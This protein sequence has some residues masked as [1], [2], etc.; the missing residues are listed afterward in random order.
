[1]T[2]PSHP[3]LQID[4]VSVVLLGSFN[5]KILQ[6]AWFAAQGLIRGEEAES[7]EIQLVRPELVAFSLDWLR[8][9]VLTDRFSASSVK[10]ARALR[11]L[12]VGVFRV[13]VHTPVTGIGINCDLHFLM[14]SEKAWHDVGDR[15]APKGP[16][17]GILN[18]PGMRNVT[19][20]SVREDSYKGNINV[21]VQ[22]SVQV[23]PGVFIGVNDHYDFGDLPP[24]T[25]CG[26]IVDAIEKEWDISLERSRKIANSLLGES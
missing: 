7:A 4:G 22:P 15:L 23:K 26:P 24:G 25:G 18:R 3:M 2:A 10:D 20:Q 5:P 17:E 12:V 21:M 13:L 8:L 16:W 14:P 11:D 9:Q 19:M 1:M 6:P